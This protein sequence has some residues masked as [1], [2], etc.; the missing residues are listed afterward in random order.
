MQIILPTQG[1]RRAAMVAELL[2]FLLATAWIIK[3]A[4]AD[5]VAKDAT[6]KML[7]LAISLAPR[8][9]DYHLRLG[10]LYQYSAADV[11]PEQALAQLQ[12][13]ARLNPYDPQVW[14][15]LAAALEFQGRIKEAEVCLR[16]ADGLAPRL[17]AY[18]W[19]IGNF[20]LLHGNLEE[21]FLHFRAVLAGTSRFDGILFDTAWKAAGNAQQ[22]LEQLIPRRTETEFS[23]LNY[24]VSHRQDL[25]AQE[26]WQRIVKSPES[27]PPTAAAPYLD[28]LLA[29]HRPAEAYQVWSDLLSRSAIP[30]TYQP[31]GQ[32]LIINGNF[33]EELINMGFA[34]RSTAVEDIYTGLGTTIFHSPSHALFINFLGKENYD[35]RHFYQWV[36]VEPGRAYRLQA[37]MKTAGITTDSGPRLEVRDPY[38]PAALD[39]LSDDLEGTH[40]GWTKLAVDFTTGPKTGLIVVAI[41]RLPSRKLDNQIAGEVWVD[42][43]SL[44]TEKPGKVSP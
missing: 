27:F 29:T 18:Q 38:D 1:A 44:I 16:Y 10:R 5:T 37:L 22:V 26:V 20:F 39:K 31:T 2:L 23:Y 40:L 21:A 4:V 15:D 19:T 25:A 42:D 11:H 13:A 17:P 33:E 43:V 28:G 30:A 14:L 32:N 12:A 34:W 36:K 35:Y 9:S 3:T 8:N 24:L 41:R 7:Q 6:V